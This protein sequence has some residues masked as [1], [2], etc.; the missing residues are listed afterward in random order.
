MNTKLGFLHPGEMGISLAAAA[1]NCLDS[2][3]W[4]SQGRSSATRERAKQFGLTE[5]STLQEFCNTC[6]IIIGVCPPHAAQEQ[7]SAVIATGFSGIYVEANAIA[8]NTALEIGNTMQA[9]GIAFID[10]G[11]IGLPAWKSGTTWLYLA[12]SHTTTVIDCFKKGPLEIKI[13]GETIGQASALKMCFAAWN[14]GNTALQTAILGTAEV[15]GVRAALEQQWDIFNPGFTRQTHHRITDV[16]RKAWRFVGEME[17]IATTMQHSGIPPEFFLGAA[18]IYRREASFKHTSQAPALED[19]LA[20]V[21]YS[22]F[23]KA[24]K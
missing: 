8:P 3:Y 15:N 4:C 2:V 12:G 14:K 10:G 21:C 17:E 6:D 5:L 11:I 19:L 7:A 9:A 1:L 13:L 16:A 24:E 23:D 22:S 18:E 20:A